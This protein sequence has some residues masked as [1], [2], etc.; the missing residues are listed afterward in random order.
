MKMSA[1]FTMCIAAVAVA[2]GDCRAE[3]EYDFRKR[4]EVVHRVDRRDMAAKREAHEFEL[5]DGIAICP[6]GGDAEG[7]MFRAAV[8]PPGERVFDYEI[9]AVPK[10]GAG[11]LVKKFLSPA[12]AR[13]A[14]REP[15]RQRF[16]FDVAELPQDV[17]YAVEVRAFNCFG[18]ASRPLA[19]GIWHSVPELDNTKK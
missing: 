16:W 13:M 8:P 4:L 19:S 2:A 14:K 9:R 7:L 1:T 12:Y 10:D 18:K 6:S 5:A 17:D 15:A 3:A 11:P